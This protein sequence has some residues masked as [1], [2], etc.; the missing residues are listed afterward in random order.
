[1]DGDSGSRLILLIFLLL[2]AGYCASA[3]IS[4][5]SL[6]IF[7]AEELANKGDKRAKKALYIVEHFDTALITILIGNNITHIA[8]A[9][10]A[11][12]LATS[13][14]GLGAVAVVTFLST[15]IVFFFSEM[16]PKTYA[17]GSFKFALA[18]APSL[19][20]LMKI[21][22]PLNYVFSLISGF[23]K[24]LVVKEGQEEFTEEEFLS[25]IQT[26]NKEKNIAE[27]KKKLLNSAIAF[28]NLRVRDCY[29]PLERV[30]M[31]NLESSQKEI[32]QLIKESHYSRFPV[33]QGD[34]ENIV[35]ILRAKGFLRNYIP[36]K[37]ISTRKHL[38]KPLKVDFDVYIDELLERMSTT[39]NHIALVFDERQRLRGIIT[40]EDIL[41]EL[42][43]EIWDEDDAAMLRAQKLSKLKRE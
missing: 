23:V 42:V 24:R 20:F 29:Q 14:W 40:L 32:F 31:I 35:G 43:G 39:R 33:Y 3:E 7:K 34:K 15:I 16:L 19:Y 5:A 13:L 27:E 36:N 22:T 4:F 37:Q 30:Q 25:I 17:N 28:D 2:G 21:F 8:F 18:I 26:L 9:S 12:A 11:T 6:D 41:E 10:V 1:M 38:R